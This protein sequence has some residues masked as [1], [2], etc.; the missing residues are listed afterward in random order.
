MGKVLPAVLRPLMN[1]CDPLVPFLAF[2]RC[3]RSFVSLALG[4]CQPLLFRTEEAGILNRG[5]IGEIGEGLEPY[6]DSDLFL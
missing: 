2:R 6:I 4:L 3:E 1:A 5:P